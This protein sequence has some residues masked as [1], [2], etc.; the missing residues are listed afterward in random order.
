VYWFY[1]RSKA[2]IAD[3]PS[4]NVLA[5]FSKLKSVLSSVTMLTLGQLSAPLAVWL[6]RSA[7]RVRACGDV[8]RAFKRSRAK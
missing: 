3:M 4:R 8:R 5:P 7:S 1:V 6:K 2:N